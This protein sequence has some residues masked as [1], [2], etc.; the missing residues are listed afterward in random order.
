MSDP[1]NP[2]TPKLPDIDSPPA[3]NVLDGVPSKEEVVKNAVSAEEI[4]AGQPSVD[5]LLGRD[6]RH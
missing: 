2:P 1:V 3:E 6:S 5:E 4:V